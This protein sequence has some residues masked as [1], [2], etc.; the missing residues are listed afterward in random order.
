MSSKRFRE[1]TRIP[2][3]AA[4]L[5]ET[6]QQETGTVEEPLQDTRP[7]IQRLRLR[8]YYEWTQNT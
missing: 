1:H 3:R 2:T 6:G 8:G 7:G 4:F 5:L